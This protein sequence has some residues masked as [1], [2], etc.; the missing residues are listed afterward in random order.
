VFPASAKVPDVL[1]AALEPDQQPWIYAPLIDLT[2]PCVA[3]LH[4]SPFQ[5]PQSKP[6]LTLAG[7]G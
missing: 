6:S 7:S 3:Q 4:L 1:R 2:D 5:N